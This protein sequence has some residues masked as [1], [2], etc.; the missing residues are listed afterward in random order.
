[1]GRPNILPSHRLRSFAANLVELRK[2]S[3][4]SQTAVAKAMTDFGHREWTYATVSRIERGTRSPRMDEMFTLL[5]MFGPS[6]LE[7][8]GL[9]TQ[10]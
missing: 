2:L 6:L 5:D 1:M 8:T 9:I 10:D 4:M 7:G 3:G